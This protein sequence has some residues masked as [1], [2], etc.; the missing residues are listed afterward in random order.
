MTGLYLSGSQCIYLYIYTHT[1]SSV[2]TSKNVDIN[3]H[4]IIIKLKIEKILCCMNQR[5][6]KLQNEKKIVRKL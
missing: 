2:F 1:Y 6:F 5:I 3:S 4:N